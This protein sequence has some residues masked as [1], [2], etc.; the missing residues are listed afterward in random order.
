MIKIYNI[1]INSVEII[2]KLSNK[3][4]EYKD[5]FLLKEVSQLLLYKNYD[6]IIKT[7]AKLLFNLLYNLFN[8]ELIALKIYFNKA[9][10][11]N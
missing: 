2:L 11:K 9:L 3:L 7:I 10:A 1:Y 5:I 6:Y 8:I 4:K